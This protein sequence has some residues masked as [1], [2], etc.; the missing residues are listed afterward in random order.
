MSTNGA[1][2][3]T[4]D[5]MQMACR[6]LVHFMDVF[7]KQGYGLTA[8]D[9]DRFLVV[10]MNGCIQGNW[11][12]TN[13]TD[14]MKGTRKQGRGWALLQG[15]RA[16]GGSAHWPPPSRGGTARVGYKSLPVSP[17]QAYTCLQAFG[18]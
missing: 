8:L 13:I 9:N 14:T 17:Q 6:C 12:I 4:A 2:A 18:S 7:V 10:E 11:M 1:R 5:G 16:V 15:R 3:G